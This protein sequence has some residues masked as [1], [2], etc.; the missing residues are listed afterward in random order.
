VNQ[1]R[2][3]SAGV[4]HYRRRPI[5]LPLPLAE[6]KSALRLCAPNINT[7]GTNGRSGELCIAKTPV[8]ALSTSSALQLLEDAPKLL[9]VMSLN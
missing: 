8:F 6:M 5:F 3:L 2:A 4:L 9:Y 7:R 1:T